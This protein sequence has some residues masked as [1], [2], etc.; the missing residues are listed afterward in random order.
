M[1]PGGFNS[2][3]NGLRL[4]GAA[5]AVGRGEGRPAGLHYQDEAQGLGK[6]AQTAAAA[7]ATPTAQY[8]SDTLSPPSWL[9]TNPAVTPAVTRKF[10]SFPGDGIYW[11]YQ[12]LNF[13]LASSPMGIPWIPRE[14]ILKMRGHEDAIVGAAADGSLMQLGSW[15]APEVT[16]ASKAG[17]VIL[18]HPP[19]STTPSSGKSDAL[20]HHF[21]G[22]SSSLRKQLGTVC[23][24]SGSQGVT[25]P[26]GTLINI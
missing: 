2:Q 13:N 21:L 1:P 14:A 3:Q 15:K 19:A 17:G 10:T 6:E 26:C 4:R 25:W 22:L 7:V 18:I 9:T 8:A 12:P 23:P 11:S 16:R 20:R 24:V 5:A